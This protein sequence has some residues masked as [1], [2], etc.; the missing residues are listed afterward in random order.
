MEAASSPS[1]WTTGLKIV[2][3]EDL[4]CFIA[5]MGEILENGFNNVTMKPNVD[6]W[7]V[8]IEK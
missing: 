5:E 1:K 4:D 2:T 8:K 3:F 7:V 6:K